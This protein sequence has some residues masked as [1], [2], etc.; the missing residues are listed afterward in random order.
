M[1]LCAFKSTNGGID[2]ST[3][4]KKMPGSV[5]DELGR[6]YLINR[7]VTTQDSYIDPIDPELDV[8]VLVVGIGPSGAENV[9]V[10]SKTL[11]SVTC[12]EVIS[13]TATHGQTVVAGFIDELLSSKLVLVVNA[14]DDRS[15]DLFYQI[16]CQ[17]ASDTGIPIVVVAGASGMSSD[18]SVATLAEKNT[19]SGPFF[20]ISEHS[21]Q[22]PLNLKMEQPEQ[23]NTADGY[24]M[25]H[26]V[27][28]LSSLV[29]EQGFIGIDLA[30]IVTILSA[31]Q[32]G[33]M[34]VGIGSGE[35]SGRT[36]ALQAINRL[37]QQGVDISACTGMLTC[38]HGS[39][40]MTMDEFDDVTKTLHDVL[41]DDAN[42]VYGCYVDETLGKNIR[43]TLMT[44][45]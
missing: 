14:F 20:A 13:G 28:C 15:C 39:S 42:S 27:T 23:R 31:G 7:Y 32:K 2:M 34:G 25:R 19:F 36:A 40:L 17:T 41:A 9:Q 16:L 12:Y 29:T 6:Q 11:T 24:A 44:A 45:I 22:D 3:D 26:L 5:I 1:S 35:S 33:F 8:R 30:D 4:E 37:H 43:V 18:Q 38:I 21:M 10:L